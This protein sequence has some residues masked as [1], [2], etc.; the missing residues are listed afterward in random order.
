M[1]VT[2]LFVDSGNLG[3]VKTRG[4]FVLDLLELGHMGHS[5]IHSGIGFLARGHVPCTRDQLCTII[6]KRRKSKLEVH[7]KK[8]LLILLFQTVS[9]FSHLCNQITGKHN[10]R[11][12]RLFGVALLRNPILCGREDT[13][14]GAKGL[15][16]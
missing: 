1:L 3:K 11:E 6:I 9:Y 15:Q 16:R 14:V 12:E 2:P 8:G 7:I 4:A 13:T 5:H 10:V